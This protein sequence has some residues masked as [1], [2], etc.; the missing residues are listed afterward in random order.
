[1]RSL[2]F[3]YDIIKKVVN[4]G[5]YRKSRYGETKE[6]INY[7]ISHIN[8]IDCL[9]D[10]EINSFN[11]KTEML[12]VV[13]GITGIDCDRSFNIN[14]HSIHRGYYSKTA[15]GIEYVIQT[16]YNDINSRLAIIPMIDNLDLADP[17]I[18]EPCFIS[19]HFLVSEEKLMLNVNM[20]SCDLWKCFPQDLFNV[21]MMMQVIANELNL[22]LGWININIG[23]LHLYHNDIKKIY[24]INQ[25]H[26]IQKYPLIHNLKLVDFYEIIQDIGCY[27]R[28]HVGNIN[29]NE[30]SQFLGNQILGYKVFTN[31]NGK[32]SQYLKE[33]F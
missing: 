32:I 20:R 5:T 26:F 4:D 19:L 25:A 13:S 27:S 9:L 3:Y 15:K 33:Y 10:F 23:S 30:I 28:N 2:S 31:Y 24:Q 22:K 6:I 16:L 7:S 12:D 14:I 11:L 17:D 18:K 29:A 8:P 1:M 21:S